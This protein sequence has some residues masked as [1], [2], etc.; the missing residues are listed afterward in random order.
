MVSIFD[1]NMTKVKQLANRKM[2]S[3][4]ELSRKADV[5]LNTIFA[6]Q[7]KRRKASPQ[8]VRK[9]AMALEIDPNDIVEK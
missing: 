6:L 5:S 1:I 8:T 2:W 7:A 9:I 4:S 3:L